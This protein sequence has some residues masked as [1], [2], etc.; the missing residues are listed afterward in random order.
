MSCNRIQLTHGNISC[1][2]LFLFVSRDIVGHVV[3]QFIPMLL[4]I[5]CLKW[6]TNF[7]GLINS[8]FDVFFA[9]LYV[10][11]ILTSSHL[12][13][14]LFLLGLLTCFKSKCWSS[15]QAWMRLLLLISIKKLTKTM[16]KPFG[17][18]PPNIK[19]QKI[20]FLSQIIMLRME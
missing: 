7:F 16:S 1:F 8:S 6:F 11:A 9:G 2:L 13:W 3:L 17:F 12:F 19:Y 14:I 10:N 15:S 18:I 20:F 5:R 4:F